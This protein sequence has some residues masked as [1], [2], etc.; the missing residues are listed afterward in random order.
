[1]T[2]HTLNNKNK[3]LKFW[4]LFFV[5]N[6]QSLKSASFRTILIFQ[7]KRRDVPSLNMPCTL[8]EIGTLLHQLERQLAPP[9]PGPT[10]SSWAIFL[11]SSCLLE[12]IPCYSKVCPMVLPAYDGTQWGPQQGN[13]PRPQA[14]TTTGLRQ[15][16]RLHPSRKTTTEVHVFTLFTCVRANYVIF[17]VK[18]EIFLRSWT[19]CRW[20]S[21]VFSSWSPGHL[22]YPVCE[23]SSGTRHWI[24]LP[25]QQLAQI[26]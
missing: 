23:F 18:I 11:P 21:L 14:Q 22:I 5:F 13:V 8:F 10:S 9:T 24:S 20:N 7:S 15:Q 3:C 12:E 17:L 26:T 16:P 4:S 19:S 6:D 25:S 1:M 2:L